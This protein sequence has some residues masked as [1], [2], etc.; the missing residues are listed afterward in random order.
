MKKLL[1]QCWPR[2]QTDRCTFRGKP[3]F[4]NMSDFFNWVYH[5]N[6]L[7]PF[8]SVLTEEFIYS[9]I[10]EQHNEQGPTLTGGTSLLRQKMRTDI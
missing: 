10:A 2:E 9:L 7:G 4:A 3:A 8:C 1:S 6:N 5:Q